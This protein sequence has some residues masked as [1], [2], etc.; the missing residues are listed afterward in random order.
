MNHWSFQRQFW[1][2]WSSSPSPQWTSC[3]PSNHFPQFELFTHIDEKGPLLILRS[4]ILLL[5]KMADIFCY[6]KSA[7]TLVLTKSF[8][9]L[10]EKKLNEQNILKI[11]WKS[12]KFRVR[13][14]KRGTKWIW[15]AKIR[16]ARKMK[17]LG[18]AKIRGTKI[19]GA[20]KFTGIKYMQNLHHGMVFISMVSTFSTLPSLLTFLMK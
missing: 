17:F 16:G 18:C 10:I 12:W 9:I 13:E 19:K 6:E 11:Y 2:F 20:E 8:P 1:D 14:N 5:R 3:V 15:Y 4:F 7:F